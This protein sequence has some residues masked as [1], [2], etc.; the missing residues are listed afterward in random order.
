PFNI[1][2]P[3]NGIDLKNEILPKY[4]EAAMKKSGGN[5]AQ[6]AELLGMKPHTFRA[7]LKKV[8]IYN[9]EQ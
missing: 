2:I 7:R 9:N 1:S 3:E 4:Y 5:A 8:D 6:A